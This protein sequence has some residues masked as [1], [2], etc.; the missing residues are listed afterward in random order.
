MRNTV[1]GLGELRIEQTVEA[2]VAPNADAK[3]TER[4]GPNSPYWRDMGHPWGGMHTTVSDLSKLLTTF[5]NGGSYGAKR[6]FSPAT[7]R[8]MIS[9]QNQHVHAPWG[10]GWALG[11]STVWNFMGDLVSPQTFGH[12]GATGTVAWADPQSGI[13]CVILTDRLLQDGAWL[14]RVSNTV[15]AAVRD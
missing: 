8:A 3:D 14:R 11:R 15:A 2:W 6:I 5:L 1:L 10:L 13:L 12:G 7:V 4:F 9:D